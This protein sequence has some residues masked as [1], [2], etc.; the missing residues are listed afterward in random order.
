MTEQTAQIQ[1]DGRDAQK[2]NI[3]DMDIFVLLGMGGLDEEQKMQRMEEMG[4]IVFSDFLA[5]DLPNLISDEQL[6]EVGRMKD[7]GQSPEEALGK[8]EEWVPDI[9]ERMYQ[10]TQVF[11]KEF[12]ISHLELRLDVLDKQKELRD[13]GTY[14]QDDAQLEEKVAERERGEKERAIITEALGL[15]KEG[16][17]G[18]GVKVISQLTT[19]PNLVGDQRKADS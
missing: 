4:R 19:L 15:Y 6:E 17:W 12:V 8:I 10:K 2:T 11:K 9:E 14:S 3:E 16:K 1:N 13:G 7:A 5:H 18:E